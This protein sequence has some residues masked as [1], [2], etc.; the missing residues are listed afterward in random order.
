MR[1][2][3]AEEADIQNRRGL[4]FSARPEVQYCTAAPRKQAREGSVASAIVAPLR[5]R[6]LW[7]PPL[8]RSVVPPQSQEIG[9]KEE[10]GEEEGR[11]TFFLFPPRHFPLL[12][13]MISFRVPPFPPTASPSPFRSFQEKKSKEKKIQNL[14]HRKSRTDNI[15]NSRPRSVASFP[16]QKPGG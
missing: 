13:I 5:R 12:R 4:L 14:R 9:G 16:A 7:P 2:A 11:I 8:S 10:E 6:L 3:D 15:C 1:G